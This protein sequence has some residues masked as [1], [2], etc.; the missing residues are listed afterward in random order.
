[1]NKS[2]EQQ[3][4]TLFREARTKRTWGSI[5]IDLKDGKPLL[6]RQ[7]IQSKIEDEE[8]PDACHGRRR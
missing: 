8:Y 4:E 5:E 7:T 6:I 3:L 1:M 2:L